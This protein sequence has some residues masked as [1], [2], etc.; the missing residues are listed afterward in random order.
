L[1]LI[2][3]Y[4]VH[5]FG[6]RQRKDKRTNTQ[7]EDMMPLPATLAWKM[8][9]KFIRGIQNCWREREQPIRLDLIPS[10]KAHAS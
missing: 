9:K 8:H 6:N 4:S 1:T 3:K 2:L 7:V 10:S 5:K